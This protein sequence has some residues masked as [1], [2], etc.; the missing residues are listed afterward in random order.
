MRYVLLAL[1]MIILGGC[2]TQ[3]ACSRKF[4]PQ[5]ITH[6]SIVIRDTTF[7]VHDTITLKA[8]DV[9]IHDTVPCPTLNYHSTST[10]NGLTETIDIKKG[11]ITAICHEDSLKKVIE[12]L[13]KFKLENRYDQKIVIQTKFIE[14]WYNPWSLYISIVFITAFLVALYLKFK[15]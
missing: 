8:N 12:S 3:S 9:V 7:V 13:Y 2:V 15:P 10:S 14:H 4:P 6:D 1:I 5:I 11:M